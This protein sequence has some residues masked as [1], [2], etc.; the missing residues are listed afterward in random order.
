MP[1]LYL[2]GVSI[3][4]MLLFISAVMFGICH[5]LC[6]SIHLMLLFI[7][8]GHIPTTP[9]MLFQYISCYSLSRRKLQQGFRILVSIHL[10]LLFICMAYRLTGQKTCFNTSHVTLYQ[11]NTKSQDALLK[12]F[13]TSHVTLYQ[14]RVRTC[15]KLVSVSIHLMLLFIQVDVL[16]PIGNQCFNTSHVT[17]YQLKEKTYYQLRKF[18]YISCYSLSLVL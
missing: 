16:Q 4:L 14:K 6:V 3:H 8:M 2:Y 9:P 11:I 10:M 18:Q 13:N 5:I 17:L 15:K 7:S 1:V 12:C